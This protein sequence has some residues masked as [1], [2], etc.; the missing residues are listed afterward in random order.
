[1]KRL[2]PAWEWRTGEKA[3]TTVEVGQ[4][5]QPGPFE[6]TPVMLGDTLYFSTPYSRA[7]ALDA[8]TGRELWAFDP[9]A[10]RWGQIMGNH[11]GFVHRGVAVWTG[12][13]GR[14]VL[15]TSR[16]HLYE[17]DAATGRPV[18][19]FGEGGEVDLTHDLRWPVDHYEFATT[20]P[21][22]IVGNLVVVGSAI[23]DEIV[24]DRDPPGD[25]QA[26]DVVT[27]RRVWRW[28]PLPAPGEPGSESWE[29]GAAERTGHANI[30]PPFT[31]DTARG[32]IYLP[33]SAP[34][35]D[36]YGGRRKG[37]N[38]YAESIVCLDAHTGRKIWHYQLIHHGLWD[39]DPATP[40]VLAS[41]NVD[42]KRID[43][44]VIA[45]KTGFVYVFD[46]VTGIPV[47]PIVERP[48]PSSD[49]L[50]ERTATT[51]PVPTRPIPFVRQGFGMEDVVDFTPAIHARAVALIN[52]YRV[53]SIFTPP[54]LQGTVVLPG[55]I[56]GAG[57]GSMSFDPE[58]GTLY[59]KGTNRPTLAK[60]IPADATGPHAG[61]GYTLDFSRSPD[62]PLT[63]NLPTHTGLLRWFSK[64][65]RIS[66]MR[67]PYGN[68][69]AFDLN[70]GEMLWQVVL[71]DTPEV[72]DHPL[73]RALN[74]PPLGVAG[75]VGGVV[76]R[77][78]LI[79]IAGGGNTLYALDKTDGRVLWQWDLKRIGQADPMTYRT[80]SGRQFVV[81]ASGTLEG[82]MLRAFALSER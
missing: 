33:V 38:L 50:G 56:G 37:N 54:S 31:A 28:S 76:T 61:A 14:R 47:W 17:L 74:L 57:W 51:Q 5:A 4:P 81:I 1:V 29:E 64:N 3:R 10:P 19:S 66:V 41:I 79:F 82:A 40:P 11:G 42:G 35:N 23:A 12:P 2:R 78:G 16:W 30:W 62:S 32:L 72:R 55:W 22:L 34:S 77:G 46:R 6:A 9:Q 60:L 13:G 71:G 75:A 52:K 39:Y 8:N 15:L 68:L 18:A 48:V 65:V 69:T 25:V 36:Y 59:V 27:G 53:G 70:R 80:A 7:I 73:L 21:P 63:F 58:S 67:P 43:A 49:V 20:S 45:G 26:F 24:H 44:V